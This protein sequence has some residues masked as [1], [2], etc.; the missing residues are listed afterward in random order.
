MFIKDLN[1][2]TI[3]DLIGKIIC[4]P[5]DT[6]YGVGCILGDEVALEKIYELKNRDLSKPLAILVP[7][8]KSIIPFIKNCPTIA[9]EYMIKHW[10]GAL[11]IIF[12]KKE[13]ICDNFTR[14][15]STIGFRMPNSKVA[16]AVLNR[17]GPLATTSVNI[18]N[19]PPINNLEDIVKYFGDKIDYIIE[20]KEVI[21]EVS[22]TIVDV[23]KD[24]PVI[25]RQGDIKI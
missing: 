19:N 6:V 17:F 22:S 3:E 25:L 5:T 8:S 2:L 14:G 1:K 21:S 15:L 9:N 24:V 12:N 16:L 18:S 13:G 20:D 10:P 7:N 4:F 23:S 11:T